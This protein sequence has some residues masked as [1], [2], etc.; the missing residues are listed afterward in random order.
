[1]SMK[2]AILFFSQLLPNSTNRFDGTNFYLTL[3]EPSF[4][5][6]CFQKLFTRLKTFKINSK[7]KREE[8]EIIGN[9]NLVHN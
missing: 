6:K 9:S 1:M 5:M 3:L 2:L 7:K 8:E 4:E